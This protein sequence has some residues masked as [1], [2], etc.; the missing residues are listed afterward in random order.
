LTLSKIKSLSG[1]GLKLPKDA[2]KIRGSKSSYIDKSGTVYSFNH[3]HPQG[4]TMK[5]RLGTNGYMEIKIKMDNGLNKYFGIHQLLL[6]AF[7]YPG[8]VED[9]LCCMH[10]DNNKTNNS[11]ENLEVGT[12]SQNNK[13]AYK[14]GL[15]K[16]N[17]EWR[18]RR[19]VEKFFKQ[20]DDV[21]KI[22]NGA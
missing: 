12:Y 10:K 5:P 2:V 6:D 9:G 20:G 11:L 1:Y 3:Q 7:V 4:I 21:I 19:F 22:E 13:D 15:N 18:K 14:D 16:G 17:S 8:Y